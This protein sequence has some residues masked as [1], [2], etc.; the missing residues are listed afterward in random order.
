MPELRRHRFRIPVGEVAPAGIETVAGEVIEPGGVARRP[1]VWWLISGGSM[2]R[3]YWDLRID[4]GAYSC[5]TFL[6]SH[7]YMSVLTDHAAIGDSDVPDD[8]YTLDPWTLARIN[9]AA[10]A[11]VAEMLRNGTIDGLDAIDDVRTIGGGH[12]MGG[13]LT[14]LTQ[15]EHRCH[16]ALCLLGWSGRGLPD[17]L[18][19]PELAYADRPDD[20]RDAIAGLADDRFGTAR[21][22][23]PFMAADVLAEAHAPLLTLSGLTAMIPGSAT[24]EAA[25]IDVPVMIGRGEHD[26]GGPLSET[27]AGFTSSPTVHSVEVPAMGHNHNGSSQRQVM[28][29]AMVDWADRLVS[30]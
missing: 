27:V 22:V 15:A 29:Q 21:D 2:N 25:T 19:S 13:L 3:R 1:L 30:G 6:A 24:R 20:L 8:P 17:L 18:D 10:H 14:V 4:Q 23:R 28:W 5:A 7:G 12:S 26:L 9:A 11:A 16:E